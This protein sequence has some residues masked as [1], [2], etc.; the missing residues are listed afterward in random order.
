MD[1][2]LAT[3]ANHIND[4][5]YYNLSQPPPPPVKAVIVEHDRVHIYFYPINRRSF[6][7]G[8]LRPVVNDFFIEWKDPKRSRWT[9]ISTNTDNLK[10]ITFYLKHDKF[11]DKKTGLVNNHWHEYTFFH[12]LDHIYDI[13]VYAK[14]KSEADIN[15]YTYVKLRLYNEPPSKIFEACSNTPPD[16]INTFQDY[17][18]GTNPKKEWKKFPNYIARLG[19]YSG[20][21]LAH[22]HPTSWV[23]FLPR[24]RWVVDGYE[25]RDGAWYDNTLLAARQVLEEKNQSTDIIYEILKTSHINRICGD[26]IIEKQKNLKVFLGMLEIT[27]EDSSETP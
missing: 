27:D 2:V 19:T 16:I 17:L 13:R 14:N 1:Q 10:G 25:F 3:I 18:I 11:K 21:D 6:S 7:D 23:F 5:R 26:D 20:P 8:I 4:Y 24:E 15:P 9:G 22:I 12:H